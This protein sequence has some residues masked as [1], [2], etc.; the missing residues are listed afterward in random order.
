VYEVEENGSVAPIKV[1]LVAV[2]QITVLL[3]TETVEEN[4]FKLLSIL[5][6]QIFHFV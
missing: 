3:E 5:V 6:V 1:V 2:L 4:T